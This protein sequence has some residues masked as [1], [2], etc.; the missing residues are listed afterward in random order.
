M[1]S[2]EPRIATGNTQSN[3]PTFQTAE[4]SGASRHSA[5]STRRL[6]IGAGDREAAAYALALKVWQVARPVPRH[7][8]LSA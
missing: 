4:Y 8:T 3:A 6:R 5:G 1:G 7:P 2:V